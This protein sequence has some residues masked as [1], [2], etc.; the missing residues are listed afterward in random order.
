MT[1]LRP[2]SIAYERIAPN[3]KKNQSFWKKNE[4]HITASSSPEISR[5]KWRGC[6][7]LGFFE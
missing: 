6:N 3:L 7:C 4:N 1:V 5:D 2:M